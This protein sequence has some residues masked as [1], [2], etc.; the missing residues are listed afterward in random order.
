[1]RVLVVD[2][3]GA[4]HYLLNGLISGSFL[5]VSNLLS[6]WS[7]D[8]MF[9]FLDQSNIDVVV[10]DLVMPGPLKRVSLV[11]AVIAHPSSPR[12]MVYSGQTHPAVVNAAVMAGAAGFVHKGAPMACL[13]DGL[14]AVIDGGTYIDPDIDISGVHPWSQLSVAE[15]EVLVQLAGGSTPK[16]VATM[17]ERAYTTIA[18]LRQTG[19][20]KLGLTSTEELAA[21]F[22]DNGLDFELDTG[23]NP[24]MLWGRRAGQGSGAVQ[25][26]EPST[27]GVG[28]PEKI[29]GATQDPGGT[30]T[31]Q[32]VQLRPGGLLH[33]D[34]EDCETIA[35]MMMGLEPEQTRRTLQV[36]RLTVD[37]LEQLHGQ[38]AEQVDSHAWRWPV[39]RWAAPGLT[40]LAIDLGAS[41]VFVR[42]GG[43]A[44]EDAG[45]IESQVSPPG[46]SRTSTC[47]SGE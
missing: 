16:Q 37:E 45:A 24:Q 22:Y 41:R 1:M 20:K 36:T 7:V 27:G 12:V 6:A 3:H 31:S 47:P 10:L 25:E 33:Q 19:M 35:L 23:F 42:V 4:V 2:D 28:W 46:S 14:R 5:K 40:A 18:S 11:Q 17:T 39:R 29:D 26:I 32:V 34:L 9:A 30:R 13:L 38:A 8:E 21:Y 43:V 15:R 44:G